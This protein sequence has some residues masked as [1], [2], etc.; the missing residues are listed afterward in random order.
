MTEAA[1]AQ[2]RETGAAAGEALGAAVAEQLGG[3]HPHALLVFASPGQD[4]G[5]LLGALH[6]RC[7]P[8]ALVGCSSAGEF[9]SAGAV[10]GSTCVVA[11]HAPEMAFTATLA[12]GL[13]G[14]RADVADRLVAGFQGV[15]ATAFRHR[16]ALVLT[17][18]LAGFADDLV[19]RLT[20]LTGGVY[21][22]FGGGAG[23]DDR[24][25]R[26]VVFCGTQ[27]ATDAAVAL[28]ILSD[29]P[30][31]VGVRHGWNP[32]AE[33]LRVTESDGMRLASLNATPA[34]EVFDA[35]AERTGQAFDH[36]QPVPF[37][38]HNVLGVESSEGY[39]LRVPLAV[40]EDGALSCAADVPAGSTACIMSTTAADAADAAA[41]AA[42][43]AL[44]QVAGHEPAVA[45]LFDCVAT[46]LRLGQAFDAEL[47]AVRA[48][49]AGVPFAGFN[50]Y[51]QIAQAEG[52]FNGFHNCT[53]VVC[54][55]PR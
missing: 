15:Q 45:L 43:A 46:R 7:R 30:I 6:E 39:R 51:G 8:D 28:E 26:T 13:R 42:R 38:L 19:D 48:E 49:L 54:V 31:G 44:E 20:L 3:A 10:T 2:T 5:A 29:K 50:T 36:A 17:D 53:A 18:A 55:I 52:Q 11:L 24:F 32:G 35:H 33:R 23:D 14:G 47:E 22:F 21:R 34:A 12:A 4:H 9:T 16:S 25:Q 40:A 1:V 37:F 41:W 27:V